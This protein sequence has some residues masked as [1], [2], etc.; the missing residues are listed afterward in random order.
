MGLLTAHQSPL[1]PAHGGVLPL[2]ERGWGVCKSTARAQLAVSANEARTL[3]GTLR[4]EFQS[5]RQV[6]KARLGVDLCELREYPGLAQGHVEQ[7]FAMSL[8]FALRARLAARGIL[9]VPV[10]A[11]IA[12]LR[13]LLP[14]LYDRD[15]CVAEI[16]VGRVFRP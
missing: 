4:A 2:T 12:G 3:S 1:P 9:P 7:L 11:R 15:L 5:A 10:D 13:R 16:V 6:C 14:E 8:A